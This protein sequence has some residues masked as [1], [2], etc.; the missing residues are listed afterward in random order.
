M[1][2]ATS[3]FESAT[4][5]SNRRVSPANRSYRSVSSASASRFTHTASTS[6]RNSYPV[7]PSTGQA[8]NSSP[9]SRIFSAHTCS[10]PASARRSKYSAGSASP[11]GWSTRT[12]PTTPSRTSSITFACV[13]QNT[14][15]SSCLTPPSSPTSKKRRWNPVRRSTSK[16]ICR[17]ARPNSGVSCS[18][19][20][21]RSSGTSQDDDRAVLDHDVRS[22]NEA[23][24]LAPTRRQRDLPAGAEAP[25][26]EPEGDVLEV[27]VEEQQ[28]RLVTDLVAALRLG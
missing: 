16:N 26:G 9:G 7:V 27:R 25:R 3:S 1:L 28:E 11:S 19:Y 10:T 2:T 5:S 18:R 15:Q 21:A 14:S 6:F 12:P 17:S 4:M 13:A 22:R 20:V 24:A 8:R 23:L